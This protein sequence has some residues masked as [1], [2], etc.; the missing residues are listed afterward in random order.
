MSDY[1]Y[2]FLGK[3]RKKKKTYIFAVSFDV[4]NVVEDIAENGHFVGT[5]A[6]WNRFIGRR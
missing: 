3:K 6:E 4:D 5:L 2:Y 1:Y